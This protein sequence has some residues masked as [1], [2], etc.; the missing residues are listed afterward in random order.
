MRTEINNNGNKR[1][2]LP[3][4]A[5]STSAVTDIDDVLDDGE[6]LS[7]ISDDDEDPFG[8]YE[9]LPVVR[10]PSVCL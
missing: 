8:F 9:T 7:A 6:P 2:S 10:N 5:V 4:A 3:S 1:V